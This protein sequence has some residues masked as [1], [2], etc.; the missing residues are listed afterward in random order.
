M[1]L[2]TAAGAH[3]AATRVL[4]VSTIEVEGLAESLGENLH[5]L[6]VDRFDRT[7]AGRVHAEDGCQMLGRMPARKYASIEGYVQL[8]A[9]LYRLSPSGVEHVRQ[10]FLRQA[11]N[12]L[13][14]NSDAHLKNFHNGVL[15]ELSPAYDIVCVAALPGFATYGQN[16]AIDRLQHEETL[17]TYES[18]AEKAGVPRRIATAAVKEAVA[19]AHANWPRMLDEPDAPRA[20]RDAVIKRL[21]TL[22]LARAGR[23][24]R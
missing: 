9:T 16:V 5:Y 24:G 19:L 10:F 17:A 11:V 12:T 8:I 3:V 21:E 6:A 23:S 14:G 22:P 20:I 15:P 2:A 7:P 1:Q 13:I 18:I 4:P